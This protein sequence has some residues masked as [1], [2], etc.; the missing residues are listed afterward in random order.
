[1]APA[2]ETVVVEEQMGRRLSRRSVV[3][4]GLGVGLG[5][6]F[7]AT[8]GVVLDFLTPRG[9]EGP[10]GLV[11]TGG[12]RNFAPGSKTYFEEGKFWLVHLTEEQGGPGF[13]ALEARCTHLG[14]HLPWRETFSFVEPDT[15]NRRE[16]W[17]RCPCHAAT[18]DHAGE[19]VFG[20]APRA[21]DRFDLE[22]VAGGS[23]HVHTGKRWT[24]TQENAKYAVKWPPA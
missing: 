20:P 12:Y 17:F 22:V 8:V 4:G 23:I 5:G 24:G 13:L 19:R 9:I 2:P 7:I 1:M 18:F 6:L 21:L 14:C 10:G 3:L 15:G 11:R 16:G